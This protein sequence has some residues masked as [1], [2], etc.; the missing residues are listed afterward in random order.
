MHK[1]SPKLVVII[2]LLLN[3][4]QTAFASAICSEGSVTTSECSHDSREE[5]SEFLDPSIC[6]TQVFQDSAQLPNFF[7]CTT[8]PI[9]GIMAGGDQEKTGS[10]LLESNRK[11]PS[12][13]ILQ[14][15]NADIFRG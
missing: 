6:I 9:C 14:T 10:G 2:N 8:S 4:A 1:T 3:I 13:L 11:E 15:I 7:M 12:N 5:L